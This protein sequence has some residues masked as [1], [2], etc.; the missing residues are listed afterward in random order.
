MCRCLVVNFSGSN[1]MHTKNTRKLHRTQTGNLLISCKYICKRTFQ[2]VSFAIVPPLFPHAPL[3]SLSLSLFLSHTASA[4]HLG[5][6]SSI[7]SEA[8]GRLFFSP[9]TQ[10]RQEPALMRKCTETHT[11]TCT[12]SKQ[13]PDRDSSCSMSTGCSQTC[14]RRRCSARCSMSVSVL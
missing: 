10:H 7:N 3:P 11:L 12:G 9:H 14:R 2:I 13:E 6:T 4:S 8:V 5:A 1:F